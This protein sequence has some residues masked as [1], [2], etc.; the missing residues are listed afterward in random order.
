MNITDLMK[1]W[2]NSASGHLTAKEYRIRL[3]LH[4]AAKIAALVEMYPR[5][6]ETAIIT[7]LLTAALNELERAMPYIQGSKVIARDDQGDPIYED[8]GP[9]PRFIALSRKYRVALEQDFGESTESP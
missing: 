2:E 8:V 5:R 4:D 1:E 6:N 7:E 3:P 9:T